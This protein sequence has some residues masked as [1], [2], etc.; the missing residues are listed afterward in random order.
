MEMEGITLSEKSEI[1]K[2]ILHYLS[3]VEVKKRLNL[4]TEY[5]ITRGWKGLKKIQNESGQRQQTRDRSK[6]KVS[7]V[8]Q[9]DEQ[10][11]VHDNSVDIPLKKKKEEEESFNSEII[12]S[13]QR[14]EN[15]EFPVLITTHCLRLL[16]CRS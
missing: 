11:T 14:R 10:T 7:S 1:Q 15:I 12:K 6:E 8:T 3:Y 5:V 9:H 16:K 4:N 2:E 13:H